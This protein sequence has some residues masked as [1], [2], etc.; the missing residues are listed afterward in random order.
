MIEQETRSRKSL[1]Q[2]RIFASAVPI[3]DTAGCPTLT[4]SPLQPLPLSRAR[5]GRD[6][7]DCGLR[8]NGPCGSPRTRFAMEFGDELA[9]AA[10]AELAGITGKSL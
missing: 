7:G 9:P 4:T 2:L 1:E 5:S 6:G 3:D 10:V 8:R